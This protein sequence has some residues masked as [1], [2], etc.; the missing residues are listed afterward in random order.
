LARATFRSAT[1][2][3]LNLA[4]TLFGLALFSVLKVMSDAS[5][6]EDE[7]LLKDMGLF[8]TSTLTV[9]AMMGLSAHSLYRELERKSVFALVSRPVPRGALIWGK[10]LGL[11]LTSA[12]LVTLCALMWSMVAWQQGV[13][14]SLT[15]CEAWVMIWFE[16]LIVMGVGLLFGSFST[17]L[18]SVALTTGVL[19]VGRFSEALSALYERAAL[20][21]QLSGALELAHS[22]LYLVPDLGLFNLTR[23]VVYG[24]PLPL[25]YL[26]YGASLSLSYCVLCLLVATQLFKRRD[27]L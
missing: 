13:A 6:N 2:S 18:V 4:L 9:G 1:R 3:K 21:G 14:V 8:L 24:E 17:P 23:E 5:L 11:A 12:L 25:S 22:A 7:R 20:K 16:S 19:L 15:M 10:A 26:L 27:L